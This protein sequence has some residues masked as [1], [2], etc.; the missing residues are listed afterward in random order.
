MIQHSLNESN[1]FSIENNLKYMGASQFK[2][3][4]SCEDA[5]LAQAKGNYKEEE[6]TAL[7]VG[8]YVDAHFEGTLDIF[9]G[10]HPN[11]Y[12]QKGDLKSEYK[13]VEKHHKPH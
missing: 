8:S 5:A 6:T 4:V 9:R 3:F 7:L 12:T 2:A 13:K 10:Q 11:I 1:Y